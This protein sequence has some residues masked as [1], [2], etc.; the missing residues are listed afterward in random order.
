MTLLR[1]YPDHTDETSEN[2]SLPKV[3]CSRDPC[4]FD[5]Q[6]RILTYFLT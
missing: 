5:E 3:F 2:Q 4:G 1:D 6:P